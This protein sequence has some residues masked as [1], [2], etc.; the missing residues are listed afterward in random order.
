MYAENLISCLC[1]FTHIGILLLS[2]YR[3][4]V[5]C[6]C[7]IARHTVASFINPPLPHTGHNNDNIPGSKN[8]HSQE[9][10]SIAMITISCSSLFISFLPSHFE[11]SVYRT[12]SPRSIWA[13]PGRFLR[14]DFADNLPASTA[15]TRPA[16][17][18]QRVSNHP[19][20][21]HSPPRSPAP[22]IEE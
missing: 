10:I 18:R 6:A 19:T 13:L 22:G 15:E 2:R 4:Q 11:L 14:L 3:G 21:T 5:K 16:F 12:P 20:P 9:N 7:H 8:M 1:L 17:G